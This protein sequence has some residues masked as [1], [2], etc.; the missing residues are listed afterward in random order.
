MLKALAPELTSR[1]VDVRVEGHTDDRP[2]QPGRYHSNW[3]LS[4]ARATAVMAILLQEGM[5]PERLSV[6]GYGEFHPVASN[7]TEDGRNQNRRVDLVVTAAVPEEPPAP[8]DPAEPVTQWSTRTRRHSRS[9]CPR[10]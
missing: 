4:T 10:S 8:V 5:L 2:D 9:S 1:L 6:A 3:E 7:A